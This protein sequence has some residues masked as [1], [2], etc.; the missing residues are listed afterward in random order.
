MKSKKEKIILICE[1]CGKK[2]NPDKKEKNWKIFTNMKCK[3]GGRLKFKI[4]E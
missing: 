4:E 3:C 2:A 1:K